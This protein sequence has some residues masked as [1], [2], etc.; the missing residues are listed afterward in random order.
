[1]SN[2]V[3]CLDDIE[4]RAVETQLPKYSLDYYRSGANSEQTLKDNRAAFCR[5]KLR[6]RFLRDVSTRDA[7]TT[8]LGQ[9]I[10][11]PVG[12]APTAMQRMAHHDG[13]CATAKAAAAMGTVMTLSTLATSSIEE[14]AAAGGPEGLCWFQLYIYKDRDVTRQLVQRAEQA[15]YKAIV[16]TIDAPVFGFRMADVRNQF[17][18]PPHLRLANF[19]V[20]S[21]ASSGVNRVE[22]GSGINEYVKSLFD[23]TLTWHDIKWLRSITSLPIITKGVLTGEDA[24]LSLQYGASA[25]I[26]SNHGGR[27]LDCV[28]ATIDVLSEVVNAVQGRC[29]VYLDG[30]V[31][32]GTDVMKA[33]ALGARAVFIGRPVIWGLAYRGEEGVRKVLQILKDELDLAMMLSGCKRLSDITPE[34]LRQDPPS[35][36]L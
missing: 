30:G 18:M 23:P 35:S 22:K 15:G 29:E 9:R 20:N 5:Y 8:I 24:V 27:Q 17:K 6:P 14:V 7:S 4:R 2:E 31:R 11:F 3:L 25:V 26:V 16:L 13:E 10:S 1:M 32:S 33:L 12:I 34:I 19:D 28:P 21:D 36:K